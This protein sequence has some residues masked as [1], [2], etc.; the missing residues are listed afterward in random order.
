M[1][2]SGTATGPISSGAAPRIHAKPDPA[3]LDP[4]DE[5]RVERDI[6]VFRQHRDVDG[7]E[8]PSEAA[9]NRPQPPLEAFACFHALVELF[10]TRR[11]Q[12]SSFHEP[13][14]ELG[15]DLLRF[16]RHFF[17]RMDFGFQE[18]A[19]EEV[20]LRKEQLRPEELEKLPSSGRVP[21]EPLVPLASFL[22]QVAVSAEGSRAALE[23]YGLLS[24]YGRL[25]LDASLKNDPSAVEFLED[26]PTRH[27]FDGPGSTGVRLISDVAALFTKLTNDGLVET[28]T[29]ARPPYFLAFLRPSVLS[30]I[31]DRG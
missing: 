6:V 9:Q 3:R 17:G 25:F 20:E 29:S 22:I 18:R 14:A 8:T 21:V 19:G 7:D 13:E 5:V 28:R 10:Q 11:R 4:A 12:I 2:S 1:I 16:P 26:A 30:R 15:R 23:R 24:L 31:S 27:G